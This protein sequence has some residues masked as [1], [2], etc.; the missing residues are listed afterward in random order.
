MFCTCTPFLFGAGPLTGSVSGG[1]LLIWRLSY[2]SVPLDEEVSS[3]FVVFFRHCFMGLGWV[4]G[5][6]ACL[7]G[8]W[9]LWVLI[10]G[11]VSHVWGEEKLSKQNKPTT[12]FSQLNFKTYLTK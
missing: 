1:C 8:G 5:K 2:D 6:R 3:C 9:W 4:L 12:Q 11:V 7:S 10:K